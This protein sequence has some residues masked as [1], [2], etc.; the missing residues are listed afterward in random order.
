MINLLA[1][2]INWNRF[3]LV[4]LLFFGIALVFALL[5]LLVSKLCHVKE[6]EKV[7]EILSLLGGSNCGGCGCSGCAAF[8]KKLADGEGNVVDCHTTSAE[9]TKKIAKILGKEVEESEPTMA[10]VR[11]AGGENAKNKF[12]YVGYLGCD[13]KSTAFQG[14]QKA[15]AFGCLGGGN[16]ESKCEHGAIAVKENG[17][18]FV[19]KTHCVSCGACILACPKKIIERI[20]RRAKVYVACSNQCKGKEVM[21]ACSAGCIGCGMCAKKCPEGAITLENNIPHID[22]AK[23]SGC[24]TCVSVC[25]R[26]TIREL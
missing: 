23:C 5:I 3:F 21:G 20:P 10:V 12:E 24:K 13:E 19:D 14:G 15:C 7:S 2:T 25:P 8:A 1:N 26:K 9:N 22:Y 6:D 11:C 17:V 18:S 4:L 16:C